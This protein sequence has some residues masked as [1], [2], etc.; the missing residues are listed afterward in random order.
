MTFEPLTQ[1]RYWLLLVWLP[2]LILNIM[3][4]E[5]LWRGVMLPRQEASFGTNTWIV[6]GMGWA[7]FHVAFGWKLLLTMLPLIFIQSFGLV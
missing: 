2:Y 1:G 5:L 3:G 4:E 7:L 6:H